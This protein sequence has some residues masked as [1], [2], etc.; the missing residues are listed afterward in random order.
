MRDFGVFQLL[1]DHLQGRDA[2]RI[3]FTHHDRH[4][5]GGEREGAFVG[6]FNRTWAVDEG[7]LVFEEGDVRDVDADAHCVFTGFGGVVADR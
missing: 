7:K 3:G 6:E 4:I 2:F 1:Q 5:A